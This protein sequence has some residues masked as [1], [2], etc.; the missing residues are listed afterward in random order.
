MP[1]LMYSY[2]IKVN[3]FHVHKLCIASCH[4]LPI[5]PSMP[6]CFPQDLG[7]SETED[8]SQEEAEEE[9]KDESEDESEDEGSHEANDGEE[10]GDEAVDRTTHRPT[11]PDE[12]ETLDYIPSGSNQDKKE[13]ETPTKAFLKTWKI[14]DIVDGQPVLV[15]RDDHESYEINAEEPQQVKTLTTTKEAET[16][17]VNHEEKPKK[18]KSK[19][20]EQTTTEEAETPSAKKE[21]KPKK[22]KSKDDEQTRTTKEAETPSVEK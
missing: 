8:K 16:T 12:M 20:D 5:V 4:P 11:N 22:D 7:K 2:L 3:E 6:L 9:D 21:E 13:V 1:Y 10:E 18:D 14:V 15:K 17:S 19:D